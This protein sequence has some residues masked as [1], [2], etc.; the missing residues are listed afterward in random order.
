MHFPRMKVRGW[1]NRAKTDARHVRVYEIPFAR[2]VRIATGYRFEVLAGPEPGAV[3][4]RS[5]EVRD[6]WG[7]RVRAGV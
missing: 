5:T 4:I 3:M 2:P 7:R 1:R 6:G